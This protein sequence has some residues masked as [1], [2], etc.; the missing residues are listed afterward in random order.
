MI[1]SRKQKA[2]ILFETLFIAI[3]CAPIIA[4]AYFT[5]TTS[6]DGGFK[7]MLEPTTT[8]TETYGRRQKHLIVH[9]DQNSVTVWV[10]AKSLSS[11]ETTSEGNNWTQSNDG[12]FYYTKP[13]KANEDTNELT[14]TIEFPETQTTTKTDETGNSQVIVYNYTNDQDTHEVTCVYETCPIEYDTQG[15]ILD[16]AQTWANHINGGEQ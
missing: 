8:I 2:I 7:L 14:V 4:R 6:A 15:N 16:Y 9:N 13:L 12:W 1:L 11:L 5:D 10:R 3:L